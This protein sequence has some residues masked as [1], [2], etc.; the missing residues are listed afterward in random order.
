MSKKGIKDVIRAIRACKTSD[1]LDET[2]RDFN[3]TDSEEIINCLNE[4][5]Y[6]PEKFFCPG[7]NA[8]V[9]ED[10]EVTKQIFLAGTWRISELYDQMGISL[11][12]ME[13]LDAQS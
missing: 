7:D 11:E 12:A 4:C 2:L 1:A 13:G 10:L 6:D 3:L 5:M 8:T 9:E